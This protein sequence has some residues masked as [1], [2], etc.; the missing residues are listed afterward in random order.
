MNTLTSCY[1]PIFHYKYNLN[2]N[3]NYE[4]G[5]KQTKYKV[6]ISTIRVKSQLYT[7]IE[8]N[9]EIPISVYAHVDKY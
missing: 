5:N 6:H 7:I 1:L 2:N 4:I 3:N 8:E 9:E